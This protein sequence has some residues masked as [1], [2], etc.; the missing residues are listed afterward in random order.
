MIS[1]I[2]ELVRGSIDMHIHP[3]PDIIPMRVDVFEVAEQAKAVGMRGVVLKSHFYPTAPLAEMVRKRVP[4]I[5]V[6]G[7]LCLDY[8]LGGLNH[9]ALEASAKLGAKVVWMPTLCAANSRRKMKNSLGMNL[10]GEGFTILD[11]GGKLVP[12]IPR[13]L[14]IIKEYD[15][16]LASGHI[17]PPEAFAL[18]DA[19]IK[20]G[21][22]KM[23][24]THASNAD[25]VDEAFTLDDQKKLA[26][27][28]VII[29]HTASD[30]MPCDFGKNPAEL[31]EIIRETGPEHCILSTD[32]GMGFTLLPTEGMRVFIVS[33]MNCGITADEIEAMVKV[34]PAKLLGLD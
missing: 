32:M 15:M 10:E 21:I 1:G 5:G 20:A 23:V 29:E 4:D 3:A 16:V 22:T 9:F 8:E 6:F 13:L 17:S 33:M 24:A 34:N 25:V 30:I 11:E 18:F 2:D 14:S 26:G 12:E 19:A 27:M 31:A 7:S 28:G